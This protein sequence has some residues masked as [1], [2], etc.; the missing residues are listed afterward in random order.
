MGIMSSLNR[1]S[2]IEYEVIVPDT[3]VIEPGTRIYSKQVFKKDPAFPYILYATLDGT[4][5]LCM[6]FQPGTMELQAIHH[7]SNT[8]ASSCKRYAVFIKQP[9]HRTKAYF[10]SVFSFAP[11]FQDDTRRIRLKH[12]REHLEPAGTD[13][14]IKPVIQTRGFCYYHAVL[15]AMLIPEV[16]KNFVC[17]KV[18]Q[19]MKRLASG[20]TRYSLEAFQN[21]H[22]CEQYAA[23]RPKMVAENTEYYVMKFFYQYLFYFEELHA[24]VSMSQMAAHKKLIASYTPASRSA[25]STSRASS[26]KPAPSYISTPVDILVKA[27]TGHEGTLATLPEGGFV[28]ETGLYMLRDLM[29]LTVAQDIAATKTEDCIY[30]SVRCPS[31]L[32]KSYVVEPAPLPDTY[33][34]QFVLM[35][36]AF[37]DLRQLRTVPGHAIVGVVCGGERYILDSAADGQT[38]AYFK[39]DWMSIP[40]IVGHPNLARYFKN[41]QEH[42]TEL[43][44]NGFF[45]RNTLAPAEDTC[46]AIQ[47]A[48]I[49]PRIFHAIQSSSLDPAIKAAID[50]AQTRASVRRIERLFS[51]LPGMSVGK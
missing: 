37:Y 23:E 22:I 39:C 19:Y 47:A 49:Q 48:Y 14:L 29:R 28:F 10:D 18:S 32:F 1:M 4:A 11:I 25:S 16:M 51:G 44:W 2:S 7:C 17:S 36:L 13:C 3:G 21:I 27:R 31:G 42:I 35:S 50:A 15:H 33:T 34:L 5:F 46:A 43:R 12:T 8:I 45:V 6:E 9:M 26:A 24:R 38:A 41:P 20:K 30:H 40:D